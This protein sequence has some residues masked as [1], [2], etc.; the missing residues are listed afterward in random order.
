LVIKTLYGFIILFSTTSPLFHWIADL[1]MFGN[2]V[3]QVLRPIL[4]FKFNPCD[5]ADL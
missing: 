4:N 2:N 1:G 5:E 3:K